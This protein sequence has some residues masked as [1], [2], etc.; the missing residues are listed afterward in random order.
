MSF[1]ASSSLPTYVPKDAQVYFHR[2][3]EG[4]TPVGIAAKYNVSAEKLVNAALNPKAG[5]LVMVDFKNGTLTPEPLK[6]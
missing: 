3:Q 6:A 5:E 1:S 2:V 4:E